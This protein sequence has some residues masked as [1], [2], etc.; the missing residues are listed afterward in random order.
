MAHSK[1]DESKNERRPELELVLCSA[2]AKTPENTDR[3]RTIL[4]E[5]VNWNEVL[6]CSLRHGLG[7]LMYERFGGMDANLL[8]QDQREALIELVRE[9][10]KRNIGFL[11][12]MLHLYDLFEAAGIPAYPYKG[13]VLSW[14]AYGSFTLRTYS[15]L[16]FVLPQKYIPEA[17]AVLEAAGCE[18]QFNPREAHAGQ[19]GHAPGQYAF[20]S[21]TK[22]ILVEL[23]TERT[24]RYFPRALHLDEMNARLIE[25]DIG[26]RHLHTFS[27][28]DTLV[29]L[30]VH[31]AKH[32]WNRLSWID[33]IASL[34][35]AQSV[36]WP[37]A[38]RIAAELQCTRL[39]LLGLS[40]AHDVLGASLPQSVL[41]SIERDL[42][43][44]W[45]AREIRRQYEGVFDP[46]DGVIARAVFRLRSRDGI[47]QGFRHMARLILNPTESDREVVPLP[48]WLA[49]L[50]ALVRPWRLLRDYGLRSRKPQTDL[51][52]FEATPAEAVDRM[53][54]FAGIAPGD[55]LYDLGCGDGR[56]VVAAAKKF[57]IRAVGVDIDPARIA[58]ARTH[59]RQ[60]GLEDR[61]Q[62][63]VGDAK[64]ID[65]SG[66]SVVTLFLETDGVLKL[67][68]TLRAQ[69]PA[70][71][72][73]ISRDAQIYGWSPDRLES[74]ILS[75]GVR[76]V[77]YLWTISKEGRENGPVETPVP[78]LQQSH[79]AGE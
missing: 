67:A 6:A 16:D 1:P 5:G 7:P 58:E 73:V 37:L 66:A 46:G 42:N 14:L 2:R 35:T 57:G 45:L 12:E 71:A 43:V 47:G 40:L 60:H 30:C 53:L 48:N 55:V 17:I 38:M 79:K 23:H 10:G 68:E 75:S 33:D 54:D 59:A 31:G 41:E 44:E 49:P 27:I 52:H 34:V 24:L 61:V 13:P 64:T 20:L 36:D 77:F 50:Y 56:I 29:M 28:E 72:R 63:L 76:T 22:R 78:E 3:I 9:K 15:D 26:G 51:A 4:R 21:S 39:L 8:A 25:V 32:F 70:G 65:V 74:H 11:G 69:L 19:H 18:A 62:F